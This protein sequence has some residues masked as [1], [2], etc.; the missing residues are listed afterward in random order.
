[1]HTQGYA[2]RR[3]FSR[4]C[5]EFLHRFPFCYGMPKKKGAVT[6]L[7]ALSPKGF[8]DQ[9]TGGIPLKNNNSLLEG[10]GKSDKV[11]RE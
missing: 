8:L 7:Q 1:M 2:S 11:R 6:S 3:F 4:Q 9:K 10:K 5:D